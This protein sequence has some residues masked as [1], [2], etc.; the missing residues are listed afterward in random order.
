MSDIRFRAATQPDFPVILVLNHQSEHFLSPLDSAKLAQLAK[1]AAY[2]RV[3]L[4]KETV[5]GFLL[6]FLPEANYDNPN[7]LWFKTRYDQFIYIDRVV[8]A[9]P[10]RGRHLATQLYAKL[11]AEA[12]LR[13]IPRLACEIDIDPPN[14]ISLRFHETQGFLEAGRQPIDELKK[15][16]S[17]Q[18]KALGRDC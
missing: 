10:F 9:E 13:G 5:A 18:I 6:G 7:F 12:I 11:E 4:C 3:A 16:V 15:I 2:F 8:V 14:P 17:L 1:E